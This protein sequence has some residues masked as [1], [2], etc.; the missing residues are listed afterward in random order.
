MVNRRCLVCHR[1][2]RDASYCAEHGRGSRSKEQ[3]RQ[4]NQYRGGW[5]WDET[6]LTVF[7][8]DGWRCQHRDSVGQQC[9]FVGTKATLRC[10]HK[11]DG[12][13]STPENLQ[14]LCVPHHRAKTKGGGG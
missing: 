4:A 14:T 12:G 3:Q 11:V 1:V 8:R 9:S 5:R 7:V 13:P 10:D 6:R 2:V